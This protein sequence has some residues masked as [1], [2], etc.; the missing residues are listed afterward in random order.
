MQ[1]VFV[2]EIHFGALKNLLHVHMNVFSAVTFDQSEEPCMGST[3]AQ[4]APPVSYFTSDDNGFGSKS[5]EQEF[6]AKPWS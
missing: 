2:M 5:G 4:E 1:I 3:S 6:E